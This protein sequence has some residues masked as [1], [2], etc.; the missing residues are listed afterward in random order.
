M[1]I[2]T[3]EQ[4]STIIVINKLLQAL[5]SCK[6]P[7]PVK[8]NLREWCNLCGATRINGLW[9]KPHWIDIAKTIIP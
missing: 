2:T 3:A 7:T 4:V 9:L 8:S 5:D 6:H 1:K